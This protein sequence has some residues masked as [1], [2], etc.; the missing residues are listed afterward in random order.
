M[1][2]PRPGTRLDTVRL[3]A[4]SRAF[5][6]SASLFAAIDLKLFTAVAAGSSTFAGAW[7]LFNRPNW[8][9][10]GLLT[11]QVSRMDPP[12]V[13]NST[14]LAHTRADCRGYFADAGFRDINVDE[15]VPGILVRVSG[16]R[17]S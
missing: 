4:L 3:Q 1:S 7:M 6:G 13:I 10:W 2:E 9:H 11:E 14:G 16:T 15:F 5:I 12:Q 17:S 8:N